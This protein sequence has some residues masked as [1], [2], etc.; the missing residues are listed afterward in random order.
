VV[1][2]GEAFGDLGGARRM[3]AAVG[4]AGEEAMFS[5]GR[6]HGGPREASFARVGSTREIA[7][8]SSGWGGDALPFGLGRASGWGGD[9]FPFELGRA[10]ATPF[11]EVGETFCDHGGPREASFTR[12][13][14]TPEVATTSSGW[15]WDAP[16]WLGRARVRG[17]PREAFATTSSGLAWDAPSIWLG[18]A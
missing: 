16:H 15:A 14:S 1:V 11:F 13:G 6:D 10:W 18:R 9:A 3:T 12:V 8:T 17:G 2:A 7:T 4:C 5:S